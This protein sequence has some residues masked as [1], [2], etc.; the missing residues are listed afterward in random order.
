MD[1]IIQGS[2]AEFLSIIEKALRNVMKDYV[3]VDNNASKAPANKK[4][5]ALHLGISISTL[6]QILK[7]SQLP[8][9]TIGRQVR[10]RWND[11]EN[12]VNSKSVQ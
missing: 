2:E 4:Q 8:S 7:S 10:I 11:L 9:F 6:D 1:R 3:P 12:Y 5:A